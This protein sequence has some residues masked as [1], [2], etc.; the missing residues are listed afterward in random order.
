MPDVSKLCD[1]Q[2]IMDKKKQTKTTAIL[3]LG[4]KA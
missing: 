2:N 3:Q 4:F 1:R